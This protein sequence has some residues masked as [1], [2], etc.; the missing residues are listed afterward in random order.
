MIW[1]LNGNFVDSKEAKIPVTDLGLNRGWA[2]FEYLR[3]YNKRPFMLEAHLNR[4]FSGCNNLYLP[5]KI[6]KENLEEIIKDLINRNKV[7]IRAE[8]GVKIILTA[9]ESKDGITP[10]G[11][12][13]LIIMVIPCAYYPS[14][15]YEVGAALKTTERKRVFPEV[16]SVNYLSAM[17]SL[18]EANA[19]GFLDSLYLGDDGEVLESTRSNFFA[20]FGGT[21]VTAKNGVLP[22]IT[23][24]V[25]TEIAKG[26][27]KVVEKV[28]RLADL[29]KADEAFITSSDKEIMPITKV[30]S[31][32]IGK[33]KVGDRTKDLICQFK[34]FTVGRSQ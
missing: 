24:K 25:V 33:G 7:L 3:T 4:F 11:K 30:D 27:Y 6:S 32:F 31:F 28:Y 8:I 29:K 5:V 14:N 34:T 2:I 9:G 19:E 23:R 18:K 26:K 10:S 20:F 15:L 13:N 22:G 12:S 21:L 1:Y 16:K 17:V